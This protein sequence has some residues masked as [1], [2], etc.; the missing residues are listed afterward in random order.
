M[1]TNFIT[2]TFY[3][4]KYSSFPCRLMITGTLCRLIRWPRRDIAANKINAVNKIEFTASTVE[5]IHHT[6]NKSQQHTAN[7]NYT[8]TLQTKNSFTLQTKNNSTLQTKNSSTLQTKNTCTLQ[9]KNNSTLQTKN[10]STLQTKNT[11]T[12]QTKNTCTLQ[13]KNT[14]TLQTKD[15]CT[16]Q[17]KNNSTL[18][19]KKTNAGKMSIT[20]VVDLMASHLLF[21]IKVGPTVD[22]YGK[23]NLQP[24]AVII[25]KYT[26]IIPKYK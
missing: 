9:T 23:S 10:S 2:K 13:T 14:C 8:C 25:L 12:L 11:C 20:L 4:M 26:L 1:F 17:T 21:E 19:T 24:N 15:T 6:A 3:Y 5:Y 22:S 7:K 16:L 18:Q